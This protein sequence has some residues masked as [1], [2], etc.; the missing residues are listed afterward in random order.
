[1]VGKIL[2]AVDGSDQSAKALELSCD[3]AEKYQASLHVQHTVEISSHEH[4]MFAGSSGFAFE[5]SD[6]QVQEA[7]KPV[8]DKA[9][10]VIK[11][12]NSEGVTTEIAHGSPAT[13]ILRRAKEDNVDM[14][15]MGS[16]GLSDVG[17]L[18]LGSVSHKVSHLAECTCIT[19]R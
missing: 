16:R 1:M 6:E 9:A 7:G 15:V 14:I 12:K 18:L 4:A 17:G 5:L 13:E 3:L 2:V 8:M 11:R 19:V 10:A